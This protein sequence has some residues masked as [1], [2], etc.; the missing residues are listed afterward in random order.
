MNMYDYVTVIGFTGHRGAGKSEAAKYLETTWNFKRYSFADHLKKICHV[1][2]ERPI[3]EFYNPALKD[4]RISGHVLTYREAMLNVANALWQPDPYFFVRQMEKVI[5]NQYVI[6]GRVHIVIDDVRMIR[7]VSL[8][9]DFQRHAIIRIERD[10]SP[11][12]D[13]NT[14][15]CHYTEKDWKSFDVDATIYNNGSV[16]KLHEQIRDVL[17]TME[18]ENANHE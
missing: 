12:S 10:A 8:L 4:V 1:A 16:K 7:E 5:H 11:Y 17:R 3:E 9:K 18:I 13:K 2:Y 15:S 14:P 6:G